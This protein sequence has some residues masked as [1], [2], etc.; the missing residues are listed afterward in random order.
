LTA[1]VVVQVRRYSA[2]SAEEDNDGSSLGVLVWC[3]V[4]VVALSVP[5]QG[6]ATASVAPQDFVGGG[7][8]VGPFHDISINA[9][10]DP[11]GGDPSGEVSFVADVVVDGNVARVRFVGPVTCLAVEANR[12]VIGFLSTL[13][14]PMKVVVVDN[15]STGSPAD[16]FGVVVLPTDCSDETGVGVSPLSFGDIVVRDAPSKAQCQDRGRRSYTDGAGRPFKNQGEC[17]A[18]ALGVA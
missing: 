6:A 17:V 13:L 3:V 10:S 18:F 5:D 2:G 16:E 11:L 8:E 14:G 1:L 4:T 12:A 15:G 9:S 7:G